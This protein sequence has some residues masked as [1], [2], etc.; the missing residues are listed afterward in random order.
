MGM[1]FEDTNIKLNK[2]YDWGFILDK[3]MI[4]NQEVYV[5][6]HPIGM[7]RFLSQ[8][9]DGKAAVQLCSV[10]ADVGEFFRCIVLMDEKSGEPYDFDDP[11]KNESLFDE[12]AII[13]N[14]TQFELVD[15]VYSRIMKDME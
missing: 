7:L 12:G 2:I 10:A 15:Y 13:G 8:C 6:G 1:M 5:L 4:D 14:Y 9:C 11:S 3:I